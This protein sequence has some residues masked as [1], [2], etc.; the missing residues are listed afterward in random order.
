[1]MD[2]MTMSI[3]SFRCCTAGATASIDVDDVAVDDKV[4]FFCL[5]CLFILFYFV[6]Y[7][8]F[9]AS[10]QGYLN[11]SFKIPQLFCCCPLPLSKPNKIVIFQEVQNVILC[12]IPECVACDSLIYGHKTFT[13]NHHHED[14]VV[15]KC[16]HCAYVSPFVPCTPTK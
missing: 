3:L 4:V 12:G 11:F 6:R 13:V 9:V 16:I 14:E 8:P 7:Q 5:F 1:M 15:H 2:P 10:V